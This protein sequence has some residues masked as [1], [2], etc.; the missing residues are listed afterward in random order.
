MAYELWEKEKISVRNGQPLDTVYTIDVGLLKAK[1]LSKGTHMASVFN[2]KKGT[3]GSHEQVEVP[4]LVFLIERGDKQSRVR[5]CGVN[6]VWVDAKDC[7]RCKNT[8][9]DPNDYGAPCIS[10]K[11][12][13][14]RIK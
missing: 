10:C 5:G 3:W 13:S 4:N 2:P 11:G 7:K 9:E 14:W 12:A 1:S 6:G 8:G